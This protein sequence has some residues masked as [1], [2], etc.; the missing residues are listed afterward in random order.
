MFEIGMFSQSL[1][2][3]FQFMNI[4]NISK[5]YILTLKLCTTDITSSNT[6]VVNRKNIDLRGAEKCA[7]VK[8]ENS[9][10]CMFKNNEEDGK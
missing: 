1:I 8:Y 6:K 10:Q 2:G 3:V 5:N 7:N 9:N 4:H